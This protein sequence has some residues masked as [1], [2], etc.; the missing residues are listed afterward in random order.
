[1]PFYA[2]NLQSPTVTLGNEFL[3]LLTV[4]NQRDC[5]I[6]AVYAEIASGTQG[7]ARFELDMYTTPTTAGSAFT[8]VPRDP[9]APAASTTAFTKNVFETN[10][11]GRQMEFFVEA[12]GG[13]GGWLSNEKGE[14]IILRPN[15]GADGNLGVIGNTS[16]AAMPA[17]D[18]TLDFSEGEQ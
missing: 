14:E 13:F 6:R 7:G 10:T 11:V 16:L 18:F 17:F 1:M 15:G 2:I 12:R 9:S 5:R 8:P 3:R 4:S